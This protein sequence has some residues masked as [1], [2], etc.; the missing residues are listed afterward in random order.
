MKIAL[1]VAMLSVTL[2]SDQQGVVVDIHKLSD[3]GTE[4]IRRDTV[5]AM[6]QTGTT[7][8]TRKKFAT[9]YDK[10]FFHVEVVDTL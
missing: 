3:L 10:R 8:W 6:W 1:L 5:S 9:S 4:Y 2:I 7:Y